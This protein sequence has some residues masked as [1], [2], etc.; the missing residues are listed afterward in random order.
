MAIKEKSWEDYEYRGYFEHA[1]RTDLIPVVRKAAKA[2]N[3]RLLRMER[4]GL[5]KGVYARISGQLAQLG[6]RR[7]AESAGRLKN[8]SLQDLRHEYVLLR[9]WLS[10]KTSTVQGKINADIERYN[11]AKIRGFTGTLDEW[12]EAS[13]AKVKYLEK[14]SFVASL[15]IGDTRLQVEIKNLE[16][17]K[18]KY[19]EFEQAYIET[20][21]KAIE[22]FDKVISYLRQAEEVFNTIDKNLLT[23]DVEKTLTDK[24]NELEKAMN[25][26]KDNY[27]EAFE[28]AHADDIAK[29]DQALADKKAE[30]KASINKK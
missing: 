26:V 17:L 29:I 18:A 13:D 24:A 22:G 21:N 2:A 5:I 19:E 7:F 16:N 15:E 10:A 11:T 20:G 1:N 3:Q 6:R 12:I 14:K 25:E 4:A 27:F 8:M 9:D 30:L 28:K 23:K